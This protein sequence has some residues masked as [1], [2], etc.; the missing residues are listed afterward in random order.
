MTD[1]QQVVSTLYPMIEQFSQRHVPQHEAILLFG[2]Y[3]NG[4]AE[5]Q[6]DIDLLILSDSESSYRIQ[7]IER[8][9]M[10]QAMVLSFSQALALLNAARMTGELMF[11]QSVTTARPLLDPFRLGQYLTERAG[12]IH[13]AGPNVTPTQELESRR[14]SLLNYLNDGG[15]HK[16]SGADTTSRLRWACRIIDMAEELLLAVHHCWRTTNPRFRAILMQTHFPKDHQLLN[17]HLQR[18]LQEPDPS[19]FGTDI[20]ALL[21]PYLSL[22]A[23]SQLPHCVI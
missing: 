3:A 18:F 9:V 13:R 4:M 20:K 8:G 10:L 12:M 7:H 5:P 23:D 1:W 21:Q 6:S 19:Q 2:S 15:R 17:L 22:S 11:V 16:Y 14:V